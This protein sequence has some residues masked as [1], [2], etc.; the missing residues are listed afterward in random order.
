MN[1]TT[2]T[3]AI[4][5]R[6][7][8]TTSRA[9]RPKRVSL[10]GARKRL[11]IPEDYK[12]PAFHYAWIADEKDMVNR[13]KRAGYECVKHDEMP[14]LGYDVDA[15]GEGLLTTNM[16]HGVT[17]YLMKQPMEFHEED[18]EELRQ[19]NRDRVADIK[20]ELND[21]KDGKYGKVDIS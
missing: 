16:G 8:P 9:Q 19:I 17:G 18:L 12:D 15:G 1:D 7:K 2:Q 11:H 6:G 14:D 10:S 5:G 3:Q 4:R 21:G 20:K 13:A